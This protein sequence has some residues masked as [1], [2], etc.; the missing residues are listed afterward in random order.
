METADI[1]TRLLSRNPNSSCNTFVNAEDVI[2]DLVQLGI[3]QQ[4]RSAA[5][6]RDALGRVIGNL[7]RLISIDPIDP[8]QPAEPVAEGASTPEVVNQPTEQKEVQ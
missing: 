7:S 2:E 5:V 3:I 4:H 1:P 6:F 8:N